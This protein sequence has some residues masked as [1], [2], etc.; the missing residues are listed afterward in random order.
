MYMAVVFSVFALV[1]A[2]AG[3]LMPHLVH[4][5][6]FLMAAIYLGLALCSALINIL[7]RAG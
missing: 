2:A 4:N 7:R 5:L 6:G 1:A 3:L